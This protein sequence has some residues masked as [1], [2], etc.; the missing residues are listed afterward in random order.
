MYFPFVVLPVSGGWLEHTSLPSPCLHLRI[1]QQRHRS[2]VF[3][4]DRD[5]DHEVTTSREG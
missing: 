3:D 2:S 5:H 4:R 1:V